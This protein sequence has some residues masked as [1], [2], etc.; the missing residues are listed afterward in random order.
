MQSIGRGATS[1]VFATGDGRALKRLHA[2]LV[3][4]PAAVARFL[5][6]AERTRGLVHPNVVRVHEVG[7]DAAG[8]YLVMDQV[9]GES[10]AARL[11]RPIEEAELRMLGAAIADGMA[12]VHARGIV[13]RDLKPANIMLEGSVPKI[14][15]FGI[16]KSLGESSLQTTTRIGT[17]AYMAPEQLAAGSVAPAIDVWAL[18]VI[19]FEAVEGTLPFAGFEQGRAPQLLGPAPRAGSASPGLAQT[20]ARCLEQQ[21]SRRPTMA[22]LAVAL[23]EQPERVTQAV[24]EPQRRR[25][26]PIALGAAAIA[27]V[28]A[29]AWPR[30]D[31]RLALPP[32][33]ARAV[34]PVAR[35]PLAPART[36]PAAPPV[37]VTP[38]ARG[39]AKPAHV[40]PAPLKRAG[41]TLD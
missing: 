23:R 12:A 19:L 14:L 11:A 33:P 3:A 29:L 7:R 30:S 27:I 20:I 39:R 17:P 10:L 1:E 31:A 32:L 15:D 8:C 41:E 5:A 38:H 18:G 13:H 26:W 40:Q 21:P 25:R 24:A 36:E 28:A 6:E 2:H 4:D 16:A 9:T 22:E 35:A 37:V 34:L